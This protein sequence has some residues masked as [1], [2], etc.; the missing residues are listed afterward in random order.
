LANAAIVPAGTAGAIS[1]FATDDTELIIDING[2]FVPPVTGTLQ[3]YPLPPCRVLDTRNPNGTFGGPSLAG[4]TSRS[5]PISSPSCGAPDTAAA[6]SL[7]VTVVP[8]HQ[9]GYLTAWP[10]GQTQPVVSTLNSL[11]GRV[12]A[13]AAIVPAGANGSASFFA[14]DTTDLIVDINGYFAAPASGG[15]NFYTATPCRLVDTR[16]QAGP[17]GGPSIS[18]ET[19]RTFPLAGSCGLPA[20][21]AVQAYSLNMTVVPQ[22]PLGYLTTWPTGGTQPVV[23]TL[24]ALNGEVVANAAIVPAGTNGSINVFVTNNTDV[25]VDTNGYFGK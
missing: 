4:G 7:N 9:L 3:F 20:Y 8:Q 10:T 2:Y 12:L 24:N 13:N 19:S 18:L 14:T 25:I 15:L 1:A 6:Y 5:F 21:P 22:G 11:D 16:N 17:L 23:S